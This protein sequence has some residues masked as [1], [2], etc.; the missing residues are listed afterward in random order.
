[1]KESNVNH[2]SGTRLEARKIKPD[3]TKTYFGEF[4]EQ[5]SLHLA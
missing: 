4:V 5:A 1:M 3:T 2:V